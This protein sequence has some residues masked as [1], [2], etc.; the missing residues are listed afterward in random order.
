MKI[1]YFV[2]KCQNYTRDSVIMWT[3]SGVVVRRVG[4]RTCDQVGSDG[5]EAPVK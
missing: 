1:I 2:E 5:S 3:Q 4:C